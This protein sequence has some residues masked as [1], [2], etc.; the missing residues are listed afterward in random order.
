MLDDDDELY[1]L[2]TGLGPDVEFYRI[3][4]RDGMLWSFAPKDLVRFDGER[5]ERVS[6]PDNEV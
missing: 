4:S 3:D 6:F 1:E 5:W 2:D